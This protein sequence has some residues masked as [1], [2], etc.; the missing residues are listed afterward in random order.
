MRPGGEGEGK[1]GAVT[2]CDSN[3]VGIGVNGVALATGRVH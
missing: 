2:C 1:D 3:K